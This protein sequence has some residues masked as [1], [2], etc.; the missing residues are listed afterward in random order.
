M[1]NETNIDPKIIYNTMSSETILEKEF[2]I[3]FIVYSINGNL[4][5][6][7]LKLL[8][9]MSEKKNGFST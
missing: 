1:Q 4:V 5:F 8:N 2:Q 6:I 7:L 3:S 9:A